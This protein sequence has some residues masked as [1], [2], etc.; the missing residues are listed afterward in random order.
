MSFHPL[1]DYG[2]GHHKSERAVP[3]DGP[4]F[5]FTPERRAELETRAAQYPP[6]HRRS[7]MLAALYLAQEQQGHL[8]GNAMAHVAEVI[9]CSRAEVEENVAFYTMFY[10]RPVGK[11]MVQVC[12]TL[13]CALMGAGRV[14]EALCETL[15]V[16]PGETD[17]TGDFTVIE[18]ECLGACDRAP[19]VMV[20]DDWHERMQPGDAGAFVDGLRAKGAASLTGCYLDI[21]KR[22]TSGA[23]PALHARSGRPGTPSGEAR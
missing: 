19:V 15:G 4:A 22:L 5:V 18:V 1:M 16:K 6:E 21:E 10:T 9:G 12:R 13:S 2:A 3:E 11:Y 14:T 17:A 7:A 8:T 23:D 20:N